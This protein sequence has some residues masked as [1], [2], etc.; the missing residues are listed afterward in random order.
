MHSN[1]TTSLCLRPT[2][3]G[4]INNCCA[5]A[6]LL[7]DRIRPQSLEGVIHGEQASR[8][9][10]AS[11]LCRA[12]GGAIEKSVI[13]R[14][15]A[16]LWQKRYEQPDIFNVLYKVLNI[17]RSRAVLQSWFQTIIIYYDIKP[18]QVTLLRDDS[19]YLSIFRV[20]ICKYEEKM[21]WYCIISPSLT[22][23]IRL[24]TH[25]DKPRYRSAKIIAKPL[26]ASF[27]R[28]CRLNCRYLFWNFIV[29][30]RDP[31]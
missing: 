22:N 9:N 16:R 30:V 28:K 1:L 21:H 4:K 10:G 23:R 26:I 2:V 12:E 7:D 13:S 17:K 20:R 24:W 25:C 18:L 11:M 29:M 6:K 5:F 8:L 27:S 14:I 15:P 19:K 31:R 3:P